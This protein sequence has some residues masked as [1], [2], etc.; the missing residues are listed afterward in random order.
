MSFARLLSDGAFPVA[1][2]ITPPQRS[3]PHVLLRRAGLIGPA[4]SAINVIQRPERQ[5]SLEASLELLAAGLDP[6]WHLVTRGRP[7]AEIQSELAIARDAGVAQVLVIAGDHASPDRGLTIREV[8]GLASRTMPG[9]LVGATL[10]QYVP[11]GAAV[12]RNLM[13][14]IA[15][16]AGYV[17]TQ[18]VFDFERL[19]PF[20]EAVKGRAPETKIVAMAMP[21]LTA[22]AAARIGARLG[23]DPPAV[24][25]AQPEAWAA[26]ERVLAALAQ[27][28]L[29]DGVALMTFET[30]PRPETGAGILAALRGA[31]IGPSFA[32]D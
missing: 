27:S 30:D 7:A 1:L 25:T 16:G 26:F 9:S 22:E 23:I 11:D 29:I 12:L 14:K 19:R 3:L 17:Q 4:A 32:R 31:G 24:P 8:V 5:S 20:A 28:P 10:N 15:A 6:A 18:P 2:E 21:L 13:P